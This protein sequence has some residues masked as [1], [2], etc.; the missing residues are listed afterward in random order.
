MPDK[1]DLDA[2]I[3][4][5]MALLE[6]LPVPGRFR[7]MDLVS[8][9]LRITMWNSALKGFGAGLFVGLLLALTRMWW[10]GV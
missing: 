7:A 4:A 1:N 3:S 2:N 6:T 8:A 10:V 9:L 5:L